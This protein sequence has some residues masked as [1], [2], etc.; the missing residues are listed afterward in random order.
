M[1]M[2]EV[3]TIRDVLGWCTNFLKTKSP[4]ARLDSELILCH[5][6]GCDRI[7]LYCHVEKPL[8]I[9]ERDAVKRHLLRRSQGEPIAYIL[10]HR[11]FYGYD[12]K[13]NPHVLIPRP[14]TEHLVEEVLD[15]FKT[16]SGPLKG[17]DIGT[18]SGCIP[19]TLMKESPELTMD[20]WDICGEAL[21]LAEVNA[22]SHGVK[23]HWAMRDALESKSWLELNAETYDVICSNPP[24][25]AHGEE[26][27]P[28]V[29]NYE[30]SKALYADGD[31]LAFYHILAEQGRRLL[32]AD[33]ALVLEI[34]YQQEDA[35]V[36]ILEGHGWLRIRVVK[37]LAKL[38]RVI[39]AY[40]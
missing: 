20:A 3:W 21:K 1:P 28:S 7:Y 27:G 39:V 6:L 23:V 13:V 26:L 10:G 25:I 32:K 16:R 9:G 38:P 37:D 30:P 22:T 36:S 29:K 31:G 17:L 40:P 2:N 35:V 8:T 12:F 18:G 5:A 24:Y 4:T 33:G 19:I 15:H 34:G 11:E 14:E